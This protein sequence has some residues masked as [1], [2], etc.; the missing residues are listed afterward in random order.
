MTEITAKSQNKITRRDALRAVLGAG[1][2][3]ALS[4]C[5]SGDGSSGQ[6]RSSTI[7]LADAKWHQA[8]TSLDAIKASLL[9]IDEGTGESYGSA[10]VAEVNGQ[11][12]FLTVGH[13]ALGKDQGHPNQCK[14]LTA[15]YPGGQSPITEAASVFDNQ[16]DMSVLL[17]SVMNPSLRPA[18]IASPQ[19][20]SPVYLGSYQTRA[21]GRPRNPLHYDKPAIY[22]GIVLGNSEEEGNRPVVLTGLEAYSSNDIHC[23]QGGSG[24]GAFDAEGRLVGLIRRAPED[25]EQL[26]PQYIEREFG[27]T[28]EGPVPDMLHTCVLETI[29]VA[30]KSL[31][32]H[33]REC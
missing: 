16:R 32:S 12:R 11:R 29:D 1:A 3:M 10:V 30:F 24:G 14:Q 31:S 27:V 15:V 33:L 8:P 20:Y 6:Q 7:R 26:T 9:A 17:P 2:A 21:D 25:K 23:H 5:E 18:Q 19:Q 28:F 13:V 4:S 22:G